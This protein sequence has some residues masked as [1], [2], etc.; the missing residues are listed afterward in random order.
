MSCDLGG[1]KAA[2]RTTNQKSPRTAGVLR[3]PGLWEVSAD[4][5]GINEHKKPQAPQ[6]HGPNVTALEQGYGHARSRVGQ[7]RPTPRGTP[8]LALPTC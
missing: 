1:L 5:G 3:G 6:E 4:T 2:T 7:G 8:S